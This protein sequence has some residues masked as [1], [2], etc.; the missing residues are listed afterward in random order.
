VSSS[1]AVFLNSSMGAIS[2]AT[3][4]VFDGNLQNTLLDRKST[5]GVHGGN[6][7]MIKQVSSCGETV[8]EEAKQALLNLRGKYK[9][10]KKTRRSKTEII[11]TT[12]EIAIK[13]HINL[14]QSAARDKTPE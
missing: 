4:N 6:G 14:N 5:S 1:N 2:T 8:L 3:Y 13:K 11:A 9:K 7:L 12:K 10:I